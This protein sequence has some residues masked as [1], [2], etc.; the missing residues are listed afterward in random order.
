MINIEQGFQTEKKVAKG[1]C[2][3][4]LEHYLTLD[5]QGVLECIP[6]HFVHP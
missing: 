1:N 2:T 4:Q 5:N 6:V 3:V